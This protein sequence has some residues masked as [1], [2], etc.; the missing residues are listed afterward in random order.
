M[1]NFYS[2]ILCKYVCCVAELLFVVMGE[3]SSKLIF[4]PAEQSLTTSKLVAFFPIFQ[5]INVSGLMRTQTGTHKSES[6]SSYEY[7]V[8]CLI[9]LLPEKKTQRYQCSSHPLKSDFRMRTLNVTTVPK[10]QKMN[11]KLFNFNVRSMSVGFGSR[12][13]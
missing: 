4:T 11:E 12:W 8:I 5:L 6:T 10:P 1:E 7:G 3:L 9:Y 13:L 2:S